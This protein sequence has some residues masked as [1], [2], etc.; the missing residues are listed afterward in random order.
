M[1]F[2]SLLSTDVG[3]YR[4]CFSVCEAKVAEV[5]AEE[6]RKEQEVAAQAIFTVASARDS[7]PFHVLL[8]LVKGGG[9][10]FV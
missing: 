6:E 5:R 2:P 8:W 3:M 1:I 10:L 4:A 9:Y 7:E